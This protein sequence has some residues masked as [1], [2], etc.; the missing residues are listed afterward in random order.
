MAQLSAN[1]IKLSVH[2]SM[3][4]LNELLAVEDEDK[5][6]TSPSESTSTLSLSPLSSTPSRSPS[7]E[8]LNPQSWFNLR[9]L[10]C[11]HNY[12]PRVDSSVV[13]TLLH[14]EQQ[15]YVC[16]FLFSFCFVK[17]IYFI[18]VLFFLTCETQL[19]RVEKMDLSN[20]L[21]TKIENLQHCIYLRFI[22]TYKIHLPTTSSS[23]THSHHQPTHPLMICS[24]LNLSFNRLRTMVKVNE[25]VGSVRELRLCNNLLESAEG[26]DKLYA[27][28]FLV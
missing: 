12:V 18:F 14:F 24:E 22:H 28:E 10:D 26:L 9:V 19:T 3:V 11:S 2:H 1:L 27:L 21:L 20:N 7:M 13:S 16:V 5:P 23:P 8:N 15:A 17:F 4:A 6:A 25:T